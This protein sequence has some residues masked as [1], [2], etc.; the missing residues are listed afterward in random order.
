M[1]EEVKGNET[2]AEADEKSGQGKDQDESK[3]DDEDQGDQPSDADLR[4][5]IVQA[6]VRHCHFYPT[7]ML[8]MAVTE[9]QCSEAGY[10]QRK[11]ASLLVRAYRQTR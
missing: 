2:Q 9:S 7:R 1:S 6:E 5:S 3:T 10:G 11:V 8:L 4:A